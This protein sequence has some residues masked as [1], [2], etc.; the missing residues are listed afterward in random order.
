MTTL[1]LLIFQ[2]VNNFVLKVVKVILPIVDI[3]VGVGFRTLTHT[4]MTSLTENTN[5]FS[6]PV[7][8]ELMVKLT[9]GRFFEDF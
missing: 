8:R 9:V 4:L 7:P 6:R 3:L 1:A 2:I 5:K